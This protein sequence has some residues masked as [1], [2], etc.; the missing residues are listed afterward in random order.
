[1]VLASAKLLLPVSEPPPRPEDV[2]DE[3]SRRMEMV[4][5]RAAKE[6]LVSGAGAHINCSVLIIGGVLSSNL[7]HLSIVVLVHCTPVFTCITVVTTQARSWPFIVHVCHACE[8]VLPDDFITNMWYTTRKS[9][10]VPGAKDWTYRT[11]EGRSLRSIGDL[12]SALRDFHMRRGTGGA[13]AAGPAAAGGYATGGMG[14]QVRGR[15]GCSQGVEGVLSNS[16]FQVL[17]HNESA[18]CHICS[19]TEQVG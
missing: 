8:Q 10:T 18:S 13:A 4:H 6:G 7:W 5:A 12:I 16:P 15:V 14:V 11:R 3:V 9:G 19:F 1:M 2:A 17:P